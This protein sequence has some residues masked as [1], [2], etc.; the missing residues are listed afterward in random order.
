MNYII[1][2]LK[3]LILKRPN[4]NI[5][6]RKMLL[7]KSMV[8]FLKLYCNFLAFFIFLKHNTTLRNTP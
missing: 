7:T 1:Y 5:L 8:N 2:F 3:M 6:A 4:V